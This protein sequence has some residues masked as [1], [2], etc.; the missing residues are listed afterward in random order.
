MQKHHPDG[1]YAIGQDSVIYWRMTQPPEN[2]AEA[3]DWFY[4]PN[5]PSTLDGQSRRSYVLWQADQ[6]LPANVSVTNAPAECRLVSIQTMR[7]NMK[8]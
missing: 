8:C 7:F 4:V 6:F 3:P 5:V 2:E 1:Q